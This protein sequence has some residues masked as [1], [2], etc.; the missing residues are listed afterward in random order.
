VTIVVG[1]LPSKTPVLV[2]MV[3]KR[4]ANQFELAEVFNRVDQSR[5]R[6]VSV[7]DTE[8]PEAL[9]TLELFGKITPRLNVYQYVRVNGF[10]VR[11]V[12]DVLITRAILSIWRGSFAGRPYV[13]SFFPFEMAKVSVWESLNRLK[14]SASWAISGALERVV[15]VQCGH[16]GRL[17][18][19]YLETLT[20][21]RPDLIDV[22]ACSVS[23]MYV[24]EDPDYLPSYEVFMN[25][26]CAL[27]WYNVHP[28]YLGLPPPTY[29]EAAGAS[30]FYE[31]K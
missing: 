27:G 8:F 10:W 4:V 7:Q 30:R 14:S 20:M 22:N 24:T 2:G 18:L 11:S 25:G 26:N 16:R 21:L 12:E 17:K 15:K 13:T 28:Y 23:S 3:N 6:S 5:V 19:F 9:I 1:R 31:N 29:T